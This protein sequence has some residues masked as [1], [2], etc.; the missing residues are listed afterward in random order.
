MPDS[1]D[2]WV[3]QEAAIASDWAKDFVGPDE[4]ADKPFFHIFYPMLEKAAS[5]VSQ[6]RYDKVDKKAVGV[7][8]KT[9]YARD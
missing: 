3:I 8:T 6:P 2:P 9:I 7:F 1:E 4:N 5:L